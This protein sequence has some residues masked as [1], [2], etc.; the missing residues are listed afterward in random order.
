MVGKPAHLQKRL[1]QAIFTRGAGA[2]SHIH[3]AP[4]RYLLYQIRTRGSLDGELGVCIRID[5]V[6]FYTQT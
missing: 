3:S 5:E 6:P 4:C 1:Y 2:L